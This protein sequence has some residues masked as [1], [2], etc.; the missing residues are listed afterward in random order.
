MLVN[1]GAV[2]QPCVI[3]HGSPI[4]RCWTIHVGSRHCYQTVATFSL[5]FQLRFTFICR[6]K[7]FPMSQHR[8]NKQRGNNKIPRIP[9]CAPDTRGYLWM[10]RPSQSRE[11]ADV[12][13]SRCI[14]TKE[15]SRKIRCVFEKESDQLSGCIQIYFLILQ[16]A[17][18]SSLL[19]CVFSLSILAD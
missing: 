7:L 13:I 10:R 6:K 12:R 1:R 19:A 9:A 16:T 11:A 15:T 3:S 8:R 4:W 18:Q 14:G 2:H 5:H 17:K